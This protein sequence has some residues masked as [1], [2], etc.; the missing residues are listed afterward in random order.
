MTQEHT[1]TIQQIAD[2]TGLTAYTLRYY[3]DIGL[4]DSVARAGNG[5]RR[6][7]EADLNRINT[8]KK[9][10]L[11]GMSLDDMKYFIDLYRQGSATA[12]ERR[13]MLQA[14]RKEVEAQIDELNE[15]LGF[16]DYKIGLYIE[17]EATHVAHCDTHEVSGEQES[18]KELTN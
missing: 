5:H 11:T 2:E 18:V 16:I 3:E 1:Y 10:R 17:E 9:L 15:I 14:H 8:L 12:T 4:I 13:E 6:Y 7:S